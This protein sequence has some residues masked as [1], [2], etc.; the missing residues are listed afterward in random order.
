MKA[1]AG[2]ARLG[3]VSFDCPDPDALARF[4]A[5]LF[6]VEVGFSSDDFAALKIGEVW[7]AAHRVDDYRPPRW[8]D[9]NAPQ[10]VHIDLAVEDLDEAETHASSL[11][12]ATAETQPSPARWRVMIDPAGHPFCLSRADSFP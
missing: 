1:T 6:G 8:P 5:G 10:Q 11:G 4:Y 9:P 2:S 7:I 12:A 3:A